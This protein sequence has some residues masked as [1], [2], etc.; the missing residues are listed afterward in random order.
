MPPT[1]KK[2][3]DRV[4]T[5]M[6]V[7]A[8][9]RIGDVAADRDKLY[10]WRHGHQDTLT[11]FWQNN[12][13]FYDKTKPHFK[14]KFLKIQLVQE[15][16]DKNSED[17]EKIHSPLPTVTQVE[18]H[19]RNMRT[20]FV[21]L[22]KL[23]AASP[24][25]KL[26]FTQEKILEQYQFL[27]PHIQRSRSTGTHNFPGEQPEGEADSVVNDDND[28]DDQNDQES[29]QAST[30][31]TTQKCKEKERGRPTSLSPSP[32][33]DS[34]DDVSEMEILQQAKNLISNIRAPT[35]CQQERKVRDFC[36]YLESE[37]LQIPE[38]AWDECSFA[39]INTVRGFKQKTQ[40]PGQLILTL[41]HGKTCYILPKK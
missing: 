17:W 23:Q 37:L 5:A 25:L 29:Q 39:M 30:S 28:N 16:I 4:T 3:K 21:K 15:L 32:V 19:L 41:Q 33:A 20:R 40:Q 2:R 36:R 1:E 7:A 35:K 12:P 14:D 11:K 10:R 24:D 6:S 34:E 38:S 9:K 31:Q 18:A 26:S 8:Q 27:R 22:L 13:I